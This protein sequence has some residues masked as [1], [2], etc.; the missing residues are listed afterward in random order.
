MKKTP[1]IENKK[2]NT[3]QIYF[4]KAEEDKEVHAKDR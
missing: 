2:N 3:F 4:L 1:S